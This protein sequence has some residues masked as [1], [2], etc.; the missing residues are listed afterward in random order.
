MVLLRQARVRFGRGL[1]RAPYVTPTAGGVQ[2]DCLIFGC[3][4]QAGSTA[5][6]ASGTVVHCCVECFEANGVRHSRECD[7][8]ATPSGAQRP[9][10]PTTVPCGVVTDPEGRRI[11]HMDESDDPSG[12]DEVDGRE[13]SSEPRGKSEPCGKDADGDAANDQHISRGSP[14]S[15]T[16][17]T[18]PTIYS[19]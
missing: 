14:V 12:M 19:V 13:Q 15:Y 7:R 3:S 6:V 10:A 4:R 17:L 16:H 2:H 1:G 18:L 8:L 9:W 5:A 11:L